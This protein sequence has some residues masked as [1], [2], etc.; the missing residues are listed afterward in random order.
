MTAGEPARPDPETL[1]RTLGL[2][3]EPSERARGKLRVYLGAAPGVGKTYAMLRE[4][5]RLKS[6]GSDVVIGLVETHGRTDTEAQV[7]DLE[8]IPRRSFD[9]R[10]VA[11]DEM[12]VD[13][14]LA[15]GPAVVLVDELAH[16]NAPGSAR[17]K[18][19]EDVDVLRGAGIDVIATLNI[20]HLESLNDVVAGIT[21]IQVR[22][23]VPDSVLDGAT[24]VQLVD[25]PVEAVLERLESG[26]IYP[27]AR[28]TQ[29]LQNFFRPG[30]LTA[31][32]EMALRRTAAGVDERLEHYMREHAIEAVWPAAERIVVLVDEHPEIGKVIR[33][34]WRMAD[35]L[36]AELVAMLVRPANRG[37]ERDPSIQ[38][39]LELAEDL[40][41]RVRVIESDDVV[42]AL[43]AAIREENATTVVLGHSPAGRW[44]RLLSRPL[45]DRLLERVDNLAVEL[46]EVR[47]LRE[48]DG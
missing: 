37:D 47:P 6:S 13:A 35:G 25:L 19:W 41:A 2:K 24:E 44:R 3:D 23:T 11:V 42:T 7:G 20:Q 29:A 10:G 14:I 33:R 46:V 48:R 17:A 26:K 38:R 39:A 32:R 45:A 21:G 5:H 28:A 30:N 1:L 16:T 31:L 12:D 22:E 15:R 34:A 27:P 4:G 18:R 9:Y 40:G 36:R 43:A 8:V